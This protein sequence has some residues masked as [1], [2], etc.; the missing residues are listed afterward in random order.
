MGRSPLCAVRQA[1]VGPRLDVQILTGQGK[2]G[3]ERA[4]RREQLFHCQTS[5]VHGDQQIR[6]TPDQGKTKEEEKGGRHPVSLRTKPRGKRMDAAQTPEIPFRR[7]ETSSGHLRPTL[8][9]PRSTKCSPHRSCREREGVR[10]RERE[11][12]RMFRGVTQTGT[13]SSCSAWNRSRRC[14]SRAAS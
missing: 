5:T 7:V 6:T 11:R 14:S 13:A 1:H 3:C 12:A 9:A 4:R 2:V 10:E 8:I